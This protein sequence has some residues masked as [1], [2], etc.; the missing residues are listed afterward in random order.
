MGE[1]GCCGCFVGDM[2]G[3]RMRLLI[4][5]PEG[6]KR[7]PSHTFSSFTGVAN[8]VFSG[9]ASIAASG[10]DSMHLNKYKNL[11]FNTYL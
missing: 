10:G 3:E 8:G 6:G 4:A 5:L 1:V 9:V 7:P 2:G 11:F